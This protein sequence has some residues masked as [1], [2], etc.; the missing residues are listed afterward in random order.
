MKNER[1]VC[2]MPCDTTNGS[3]SVLSKKHRCLK[4]LACDLKI[5]VKQATAPRLDTAMNERV[6]LPQGNAV[7]CLC[8]KNAID[9]M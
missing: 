6:I 8:F 7:W 9:F 2:S 4:D 1:F 3:V 5:V